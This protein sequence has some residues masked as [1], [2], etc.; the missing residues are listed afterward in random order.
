MTFLVA[1]K[2]K[3]TKLL[4]ASDFGKK[5]ALSGLKLEPAIILLFAIIIDNDL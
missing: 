1:Y 3:R 5:E 2:T 4:L